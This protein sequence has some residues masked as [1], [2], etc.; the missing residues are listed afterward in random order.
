LALL[1][2]PADATRPAAGAKSNRALQSSLISFRYRASSTQKAAMIDFAAQKF[3][4]IGARSHGTV[5]PAGDDQPSWF[6]TMR[7]YD[8]T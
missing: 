3:A 7:D 2:A 8:W 6:Q 1:F 5:R 4:D